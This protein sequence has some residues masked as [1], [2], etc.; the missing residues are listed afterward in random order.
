M[1]KRWTKPELRFAKLN[2]DGVYHADE[3]V[4]ASVAILCDIKGNFIDA[5]CIYYPIDAN[6]VTSEVVATRDGLAFAN[7]MG[8]HAIE[9]ESDSLKV[10]NFCTG[11]DHWWDAATAIYTEILDLATDV[12]KVNFMHCFR[13]ANSVA[14]ELAQFSFHNKLSSIWGGDPSSCLL[15]KLADDV[16]IFLS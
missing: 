11:H 8:F 13:E 16:N 7:T 2:V 12:G 9:A 3:G 6:A 5:S 10:V 14:H 15:S 4:G 1:E